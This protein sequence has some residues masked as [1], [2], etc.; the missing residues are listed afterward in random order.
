MSGFGSASSPRRI[1]TPS[2]PT[3]IGGLIVF[4]V[5]LG[6]LIVVAEILGRQAFNNT[7]HA[8][9]ILLTDREI[10]IALLDM[11]TSMR[12][13]LLADD[14]NFL[15]PYRDATERLP[16]LWNS[17]SSR[18]D[19]LQNLDDST[20][21]QLH[22]QTDLFK[23]AADR[24]HQEWGDVQ[25]RNNQ[26]GTTLP[27]DIPRTRGKELFDDFRRAGTD[28]NN[29]IRAQLN[30]YNLELSNIRWVELVV[31][32]VL[33]FLAIAGAI[34][35]LGTARR[36]L[37]LEMEATRRIETEHQQ[38]QAVVDNIP[39]A[40]RVADAPDSKVILQNRQA[41]EIFPAAIWNNMSRLERIQYFDL[42][43]AD[44]EPITLEKAPIAN[45]IQE[46]RTVRD[47][48]LLTTRPETGTKHLMVSAAPIKNK[49]DSVT[50]SVLV[51][52]DVTQLQAV[53][54]RKDEFI[55]IAAHELR[56]PLAAL[57][58]YNHLAQRTLTKVKAGATP[59]EEALPTIERHLGEMSKQIERLTRLVAR[60]LDASRIQLGKIV[61]EK[62]QTDLV[63]MAAEVIAN[64]KTTDAE[65]HA[66]E[67]TAPDSLVGNWDLIR[68]E[69]V[70]TNL[71]DNA[72]RYSP[73]GTPVHISITEDHGTAHL[74]VVDRGPGI[75]E[76]QRPHLFN[77][78][79]GPLPQAPTPEGAQAPRKKR[80]LG[81]GLYVSTEII[82]AHGGE[83]GV[84]PNPEGGSIFWIAL[85]LEA[86]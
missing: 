53:D 24:W 43:T 51:M 9:S 29:T 32:V 2:T 50:A 83:I 73:P 44:G 65:A 20:R 18:I 57:V 13:Y 79:Y 46:G 38:L 60:L 3:M 45:S 47:I 15:Q 62:S 61:L 21:T 78:F 48:E 28:L 70:I 19:N 1:P 39:I 40:V 25:I 12:G 85:P 27:A 31:I 80:G 55:A 77:R 76:D 5:V 86:E 52:R 49:D 11:E 10:N 75:T 67:L 23:A 82:N 7:E 37:R 84:R 58:G 81:I 72:L 41:E 17:I 34:I 64:A 54:H 33:G 71:L 68:M 36:E 30:S 4:L 26:A 74:E 16:T 59:A 56:N 6:T 35:T 42:R 8:E 69:Q 63:K 22:R 14:E 66:I